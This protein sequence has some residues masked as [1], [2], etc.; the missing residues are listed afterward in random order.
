MNGRDPDQVAAGSVIARRCRQSAMA[1]LLLSGAVSSFVGIAFL[2]TATGDAA[3]NQPTPRWWEKA[4]VVDGV[5]HVKEAPIALGVMLV[6]SAEG[7]L[8]RADGKGWVVIDVSNTSNEPVRLRTAVT[9]GKMWPTKKV[10]YSRIGL[11]SGLGIAGLRA[12]FIDQQGKTVSVQNLSPPDSALELEADGRKALWRR[13]QGPGQAGTYSLRII[14]DTSRVCAAART[15]NN[16]SDRDL[17]PAFTAIGVAEGVQ[18]GA[19]G[20]E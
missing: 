11:C 3:T 15:Y 14:L 10:S 7:G 8:L 1:A 2:A 20:T 9:A 6:A 16:F 12:E 13:I 19:P 17:E 5:P 4:T 18:V